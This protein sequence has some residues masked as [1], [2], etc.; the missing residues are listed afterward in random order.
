MEMIPFREK[1]RNNNNCFSFYFVHKLISIGRVC[2]FNRIEFS[3]KYTLHIDPRK[4][5]VKSR[6]RR[7]LRAI[8]G[9]HSMNSDFTLDLLGNSTHLSAYFSISF[10][11]KSKNEVKRVLLS[12]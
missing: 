9:I 10:S 3:A 1:K 12:D 7:S 11:F 4:N 5:S 8:F 2:G 6:V